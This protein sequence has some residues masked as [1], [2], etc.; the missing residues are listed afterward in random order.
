LI[1]CGVRQKVAEYSKVLSSAI[2][3]PNQN[4]DERYFTLPLYLLDIALSS[5]GAKKDEFEVITSKNLFRYFSSILSNK[6]IKTCDET[7]IVSIN[8]MMQRNFFLM[9]LSHFESAGFAGCLCSK[10]VSICN[11]SMVEVFIHP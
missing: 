11:D 1:S 7:M 10:N 8:R 3:T 4:N 2:D 5:R 9:T 6:I